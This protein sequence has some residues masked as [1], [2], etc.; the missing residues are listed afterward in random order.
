MR[1]VA[2]ALLML[3]CIAISYAIGT[4]L[5]RE[6]ASWQATPGSSP[7]GAVVPGR[8]RGSTPLAQ[9]VPPSANPGSKDG[10]SKK[11]AIEAFAGDVSAVRSVG[12]NFLFLVLLLAFVWA[13]IR[14]VRRKSIVIDLIDVPKDLAEKGYTPHVIALRLAAEV[15]AIQ[16]TAR[17]RGH[18]DETFELSATQIDFTV[19]TAGISYRSIIRY[20][21]QVFGWPEERVRGEI[22][23]EAAPMRIVSSENMPDMQRLRIALRTRDGR[24]TPTDLWVLS[25]LEVPELLRKAAFEIALLVDPY[26]MA[27]YWFWTEQ[28]ERKFNKTFSVIKQC[29]R[30]T[31]TDQH[32]RA[33]VLWGNALAVQKKFDEAEEKY[34]T[35]ASLAPRAAPVYNSWGNLMRTRRRVDEAGAMYWKALWRDYRYDAA[36][37]NLG[38]VYNERHRY[39]TAIWCF[40]RVLQ[41]DP[42]SAG[43][44]NGWGYALWKLGDHTE[45]KAKFARAIDL[46]PQSGWAYLNFARLLRMQRQFEAAI[47][48]VRI[49]AE[50][51]SIPAEAYGLWGDILV[52]MG[53]F[54]EAAQVYRRATTTD[55][56]LAN[57]L[58]GLAFLLWRQRHYHEAACTCA[59]AI[60]VD[61]YHIS[62]WMGWAESLRLSGAYDRAIEKYKALL[63]LYPY[64]ASASVG[65]GQILRSRHQLHEAVAKFKDAT[66]IDP[67]ESWAW[68][69]WGEVLTDMHR[70]E[71]AL[72]KFHKAVAANPWD[73]Y[74]YIGCGNVLAALG[75][76]A[77]ALAQYQRACEL[78]GRNSWAWRRLADTLIDLNHRQEAYAALER[79]VAAW[80]NEPRIYIEYGHVLQRLGRFDE[81]AS[82]YEEA[83]RLDQCNADALIG[84]AQVLRWSRDYPQA[85]RLLRRAVTVEPWSEWARRSLGTVLY[86][87][88]KTAV[89]LRWFSRA[90]GRMPENVALLLDWSDVLSRQARQ[91]D[92]QLYTQAEEK[93]CRAVTIDPWNTSPLR[94]RGYLLLTL[95]RPR[96]A[97]KQFERAAGLDPCDWRAWMGQ[98][99]TLRKLKRPDEAVT[100]YK[101]A[102]VFQ[103]HNGELLLMLGEALQ[104]LGRYDES[105]TK[106]EYALVINPQSPHGA[107]LLADAL[108]QLGHFYRAIEQYQYAVREGNR[109]TRFH[110]LT[111]WGAALAKLERYADAVDKFRE[112]LVIDP[113]HA[114][115]V[116]GLASA[117]QA[118]AR[119]KDDMP[120]IGSQP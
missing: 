94:A 25:D 5:R 44:W 82:R 36:W 118:L 12:M 107:R 91:G 38:L 114:A 92:T 26:L 112:A 50:Q 75:R 48:R 20:I 47:A 13:V 68:R 23:R 63:V 81:A 113:Y 117:E 109:S 86:E 54:E 105:M 49:A 87:T 120:L 43:A 64:Q 19:P 39:R 98:G 6:P 59:Q 7:T 15:N 85:L 52:D 66:E 55:P 22:V 11:S 88:G 97:L 90:H 58:A 2:V 16:R 103:P 119:L 115:A 37:G 79:A 74:G 3:S 65:W 77:E 53:Q 41:L 106:I 84:Q 28:R 95:D 72:D 116:E 93:L 96:E 110:A 89:A 111:G 29:L 60:A 102:T 8:T 42:R 73:S 57:G 56:S 100:A 32:Y 70:Y 35:A 9:P 17:V 83:A 30:S 14:E 33:Y 10:D 45:A 69:S 18:A 67:S 21:R 78:D 104:E 27:T 1:R 34:C 4:H 62:A 99:D 24:T 40:Q 71:A 101:R 61:R 51:T 31:A 80:P 46:D 76:L 108:R